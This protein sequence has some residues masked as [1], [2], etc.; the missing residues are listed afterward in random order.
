F[1]RC[2]CNDSIKQSFFVNFS[3]TGLTAARARGRVG[4]RPKGLSPQA[5]ATALAAETLYRERKLSVAAI[6]QK[7]H[8]S[9]STLYSYLRHRGVRSARTKTGAASIKRAS[10]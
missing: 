5:E 2:G 8:L 3:A 6:A 7:L 1:S 4:G 9:K 10:R